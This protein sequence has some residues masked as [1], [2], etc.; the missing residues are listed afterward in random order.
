[1]LVCVQLA[2]T[3]ENSSSGKQKPCE[4]ELRN[5]YLNPTMREDEY[6]LYV[7]EVYDVSYMCRVAK[8]N[9]F[10]ATQIR[11]LN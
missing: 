7:F 2:N 4:S 11:A 9:H 10:T 5:C 1:M 6:K 3:C 8:F